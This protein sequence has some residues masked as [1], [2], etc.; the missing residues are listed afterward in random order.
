MDHL[1]TKKHL[2]TRLLKDQISNGLVFK[3]LGY[4]FSYSCGPNHS[5]SGHFCPDFKWFLTKWQPF[6][7]ISNSW[8]SKFISHSKSRLF[9][10][11]P[12]FQSF[13]IQTNPYFRSPLSTFNP[14]H[15]FL[16]HWNFFS[17]SLD[18]VTGEIRNSQILFL[19]VSLLLFLLHV[20]H[21]LPIQEVGKTVCLY[22]IH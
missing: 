1:N 17:L 13:K 20:S 7:Q 12:H 22:V 18:F 15:L 16:A 21:I 5:K 6:V 8:A 2:K 3:G 4:S 14:Q 9:A 10:N 11:Q 19:G